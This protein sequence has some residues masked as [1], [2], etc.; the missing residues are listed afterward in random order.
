MKKFL[1]KLKKWVVGS[2]KGKRMIDSTYLDEVYS[3]A[4][5]SGDKLE[6]LSKKKR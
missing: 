6:H 4:A 2:E 3:K 5:A 1:D